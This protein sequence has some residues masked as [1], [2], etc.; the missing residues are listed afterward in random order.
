MTVLLHSRVCREVMTMNKMI[1][2]FSTILL[3]V[4]TGCQSQW[5][6]D[7]NGVKFYTSQKIQDESAYEWDGPV[8]GD[9]AN[10][11]G[12]LT[13]YRTDGTVADA[14]TVE[15]VWGNIDLEGAPEDS[16]HVIN[17][18]IHKGKI[19]GFAVVVQGEYVYIGEFKNSQ[20]HGQLK[21]YQNGHL[22]YDG[23]WVCGKR[24]GYGTAYYAGKEV[25]GR[26]VANRLEGE[27]H[28][29][30]EK[31]SFDGVVQ[32][33]GTFGNNFGTVMLANGDVY[34]G[35]WRNN[36]YEGYGEYIYNKGG[37][38]SGEWKAGRQNGRG[39]YRTSDF[40]YVGDWRD[41]QMDG[42][43]TITF[44]NGIVITGIFEKG[45][46]PEHEYSKGFLNPFS[47]AKGIYNV[48]KLP[49]K[50]V[51]CSFRVAKTVGKGAYKAGKAS[52]RV[53]KTAVHYA[54]A[55]ARFAKRSFNKI[56]RKATKKANGSAKPAVKVIGAEKVTKLGTVKKVSAATAS[57]GFASAYANTSVRAAQS[58]VPSVRPVETFAQCEKA[59]AS[60]HAMSPIKLTPREIK[61]L[62]RGVQKTN[63]N[64]ISASK[65]LG[66]LVKKKT[67]K[68]LKDGY[69]EFFIRLKKGSP[70]D[71][72]RLM[73]NPAIKETVKNAIYY[74]RAT[75]EW[76]PKANCDKFL[77]DP[78]YGKDGDL[79][80]Y[81]QE[82]FKQ[83]TT[84]VI[85]KQGLLHNGNALLRDMAKADVTKHGVGN[86]SMHSD[87]FKIL[88]DYKSKSAKGTLNEIRDYAKGY[89]NP[90]A[91]KDFMDNVFNPMM[92]VM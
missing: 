74:P 18:L 64:V 69:R 16:N 79:L 85:D 88:E 50:V 17:G 34:S 14:K 10:G 58:F 26:W 77:T 81:M 71:V 31:I 30:T 90:E 45:S 73:A 43:G 92:G 27:I 54:L 3:L 19:N 76:L 12:V 56:Y 63:G 23:Q 61:S 36:V 48:A 35:Q 66:E 70:E 4:F 86:A 67:G 1:L 13:R 44:E 57:T 89:L 59:V 9:V 8:F 75:H 6:N 82:V 62:E 42:E 25:S 22:K 83:R 55:P 37:A 51:K 84:N 72:Q 20:P 7:A 40:V 46:F 52:F 11:R 60:L 5:H 47:V 21:Y 65:V 80:F 41:G 33:E 15:A 53:A 39:T 29:E 2:L 91:Y 24:Y 68:S 87:L 32:Y 78:R 49:F 38:Y 28:L